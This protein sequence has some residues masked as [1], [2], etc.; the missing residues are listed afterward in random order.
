MLELYQ[1]GESLRKIGERFDI[2]RQRVYRILKQMP[3]YRSFSMK[4]RKQQRIDRLLPLEAE[5]RRL[6]QEKGANSKKVAA[7]LGITVGDMEF[8]K[9]IANIRNLGPRIGPQRTGERVNNWEIEGRNAEDPSM[10]DCK[11]L[12][13]G[14]RKPVNEKNLNSG[15]SKSCGCRR[16][17]SRKD[18]NGLQG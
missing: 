4:E 18:E 16:G 5:A 8:L 11:C 7:Q 2:S 15:L 3:G 9:G 12:L 14:T 1:Q 17:Y 6:L 10:L 13:C